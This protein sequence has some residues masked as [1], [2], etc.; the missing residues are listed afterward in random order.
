MML[1]QMN[2]MTISDVRGVIRFGSKASVR[3]ND[4][5]PALGTLSSIRGLDMWLVR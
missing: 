5:V 3:W 1:T 4:V 2:G